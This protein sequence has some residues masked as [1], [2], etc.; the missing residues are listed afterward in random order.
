MSQLV[1]NKI[2]THLIFST[3]VTEKRRFHHKGTQQ[4][5][6]RDRISVFLS[7]LHSFKSLPIETADFYLEFDE[8]TSWASSAIIEVIQSLPFTI[9]L[10][11]KRLANYKDWMQSTKSP[12][13]IKAE[14]LLL[15]TYDDHIFLETS[16]NELNRL[17]MRRQQIARKLG[18]K[19]IMVHLSHYPETHGLLMLAKASKSLINVENDLLVP[20]VTP[21]GT[22]VLAPEDYV[23]WFKTDFMDGKKFVA[24]ENPF[25]K[26]LVLTEA[27]YLIPRTEIFRHLDAYSHVRLHGWPYQVLDSIIK[28]NG[29]RDFPVSKEVQWHH[30][31]TINAPATNFDTTLLIDDMVEGSIRGFQC[32]ILKACAVRF[33]LDSIKT[34]NL[35]YKLS[36]FSVLSSCIITFINS[37][38]F[39]F[40]V[41]RFIS[42]VPFLVIFHFFLP[43][44]K[45]FTV[46]NPK[47]F[48][49]LIQASLTGYIRTFLLVS[50]QSLKRRFRRTRFIEAK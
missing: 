24:P 48:S 34:T 1:L 10:N 2:K 39:R 37:K 36:R 19:N 32:G 49:M 42:E 44:H 5:A 8:T 22:I 28:S 45:R 46:S 9:N 18:K 47:Y 31:S 41:Y 16:I 23:N 26:S 3:L 14:S 40:G 12:N 17:N 43:V 11:H 21:I 29:V 50:K 20:V 38:S 30:H 27:F 33:S 6:N 7:T 35:I 15:L 4:F 13:L 25:G